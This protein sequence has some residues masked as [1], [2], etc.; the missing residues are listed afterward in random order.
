MNEGLGDR[1]RL[2]G[3]RCFLLSPAKTW[4]V[5]G[6]PGWTV[7][8]GSDV[9]GQGAWCAVAKKWAL[10]SWSLGSVQGQVHFDRRFADVGKIELRVRC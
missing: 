2:E 7:I 6:T 9:S 10:F 1:W 8:P 3:S 4:A 5:G